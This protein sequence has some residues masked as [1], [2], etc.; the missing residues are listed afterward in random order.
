MIADPIGGALMIGLFV[1]GVAFLVRAVV[2]IRRRRRLHHRRTNKWFMAGYRAGH[3]HASR[4]TVDRARH[5][6]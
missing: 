6:A 5:S 2:H 4:S 1:A 3:R